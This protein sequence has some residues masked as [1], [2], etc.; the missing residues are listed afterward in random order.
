MEVETVDVTAIAVAIISAGSSIASAIIVTR[1]Q[2]D[3]KEKAKAINNASKILLITCVGFMAW[4]YMRISASGATAAMAAL[5]CMGAFALQGGQLSNQRGVEQRNRWF[6]GIYYVSVVLLVASFAVITWRNP[7]PAAIA[8]MCCVVVG[9][10][11]STYAIY[12]GS[13]NM[14]FKALLSLS[15][16]LFVGSIVAVMALVIIP[17]VEAEVAPPGVKDVPQPGGKIPYTITATAGSGGSIDPTGEVTVYHGD[18]QTFTITPD[19]NCKVDSVMV[20]GSPVRQHDSYTFTNVTD[21]HTIEASFAIHKYMITVTAG[22]N[23]SITPSGNVY[24]NDGDSQ[25]FTITPDEYYEVED[26][27]VDGGSV[28]AVTSYTF[29]NVTDNHTIEASF[30]PVLK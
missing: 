7:E 1:G 29:T 30:A 24:V 17:G 5:A 21:N 14:A 27:L 11:A 28:G 16:I 9:V 13:V 10:S 6:K 19:A 12:Q 2:R 3:K 15:T 4:Q 22:A 18:N 26:V 25:T 8:S 20:D 23:G